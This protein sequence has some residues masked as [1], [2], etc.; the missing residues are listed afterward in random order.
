MNVEV[1]A[2]RDHLAEAVAGRTIE[3][4][5]SAITSYDHAV[6]VIAGGTLP[7]IIYHVIATQFLDKVDWSKVTFVM[8]DE[9][10]GP[11][12][13][14]DNNWFSAEQT[15]LKFIPQATFLRPP[16]D[17]TAEIG[18]G[19]YN[20]KIADLPLTDDGFPRLDLVWLGMGEDGHTLSLFPGHPGLAPT[21][22]FVIP[23]HDS[24]KP[25]TDRI[26]LTFQALRGA[27]KCM[28]LTVGSGKAP[29]IQT[30]KNG[31]DLPVVTASKLAKHTTWFM[32]QAA[33]T[34]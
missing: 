1:F 4:L 18:A 24:P 15:L 11:L 7:P 34:F 33:A 32:D 14:P 20:Q 3:I 5:N 19:E 31:A 10:I 6:W 29:I 23:I 28:I 2:D 16:S 21:D 8:G 25:P 12:D 13:S 22:Q 17:Q 9:R 30:I 26:T 27:Q